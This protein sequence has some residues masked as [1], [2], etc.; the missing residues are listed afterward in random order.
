MR[1]LGM[2]EL[3]LHATRTHLEIQR[4][5]ATLKKDRQVKYF[6]YVL[7]LQNNK[8]YV[9]T[10]DNIFTRLLDHEGRGRYC[11]KWVK[12]HGP[13][14]RVLE[15]IQNARAE[16]EKNKTLEWMDLMGWENVRGGP[17][18]KMDLQ[19]PP[20]DLESFHRQELGV[21]T[22]YVPRHEIE[23]IH[24]LVKGMARDLETVEAGSES[25][26]DG[27]SASIECETG[28]NGT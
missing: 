1:A 11:A 3:L 28:E 23:S 17:Y 24:S 18:C 21:G 7:Q 8:Y 25:G 22:T 4:R 20:T 2:K 5:Y 19:N 9:G 13:V 6:V 15:I 27:E 14:Q 16:D 10:T 26:S 12:L